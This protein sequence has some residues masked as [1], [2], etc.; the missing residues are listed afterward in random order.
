[1]RN[2]RLNFRYLFTV[3]LLV[4]GIAVHCAELRGV[5]LTTNSGLDWP[6]NCHDVS[7]QKEMLRDM[8][9]RLQ[10]AHV[11]L[12]LFQVQ[13]NGDV[14]WDSKYQPVMAE[15]TGSGGRKPGFDICRFVIDECHKRDMK[16][17]AWIVPFRIGS[18]KRAARY[19]SSAVKHPLAAHPERCILFSGNYYLDPGNPDVREYLV[20]LY[21]ELVKKYDFDGI[22]LDYTRYPGAGFNDAASFAKYNGRH[23]NRDDWRRDNINTFVADF[24]K[25]VKK[26]RPDIV[27]GSAPIGTYKNVN[28]IHNATAFDQFH[29]DP[30]Q[31]AASGHHDLVIPQMYWDESRGFSTHINTWTEGCGGKDVVIGLAPYRMTDNTR[32]RADVIIDQIKKAR[33]ARGVKGVCF[34]RAEH[35]LGTHPEVKRLY[36]WLVANPTEDNDSRDFVEKFLD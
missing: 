5:W 35:L 33:K 30:V 9:D 34:F 21:R 1:M 13:A 15:V 12:V 18:A 10:K 24:Y 28:S 19:A 27:V 11:N 2:P 29:Q 20:E 31:W 14:V 17:H 32:W 36:D 23:L 16:C 6:G 4:A 7:G 25:A 26:E 22:N 3:L 8:L